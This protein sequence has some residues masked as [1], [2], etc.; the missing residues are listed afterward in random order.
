MP[1]RPGMKASAA[2]VSGASA[3]PLSM[4]PQ[5]GGAEI[6]FRGYGDHQFLA[7]I[8]P[9][10]TT[11]AYSAPVGSR[12]EALRNAGLTATV[13]RVTASRDAGRRG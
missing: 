1:S 9:R 11:Y 8:R 13:T 3:K 10:A 2:T 7:E 12:E 5:W 4:R 6:T